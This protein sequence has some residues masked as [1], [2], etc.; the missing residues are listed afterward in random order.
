MEA[1]MRSYAL[2]ATVLLLSGCSGFGK[3][4]DD[5]VTLPGAN[6]EAPTGNSETMQRVRGNVVVASTPIL[7]QGENIWPSR[8]P[9]LPTLS[10]VANDEKG[11]SLSDY[12]RAAGAD[13]S[14]SSHDKVGLNVSSDFPD[15][16]AIAAGASKQIKEGVTNFSEGGLPDHIEDNA[17][18]YMEKGQSQ[19]IIVPNGDG[20]NTVISP[21]GVVSTVPD[22][23]LDSI[24]N[25]MNQKEAPKDEKEKAKNK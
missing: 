8:P 11:F 14:T 20:T 10:Q 19:P 22:S 2:L 25:K 16:A 17:N 7:P 18:K 5:T 23:K 13:V 6:P 12:G 15:N 1:I 21:D 9:A 4:I 24:K 3:F